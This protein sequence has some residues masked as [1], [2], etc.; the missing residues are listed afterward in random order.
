MASGPNMVERTLT[1]AGATVSE[2]SLA[3]EQ[4][5]NGGGAARLQ[6]LPLFHKLVDLREEAA[7]AAKK[8]LIVAFTSPDRFTRN[9]ALARALFEWG[10]DAAIGPPVHFLSVLPTFTG[11]AR[12]SGGGSRSRSGRVWRR[13]LLRRSRCKARTAMQWP[14][15]ST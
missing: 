8:A 7:K 6:E 11:C 9:E 12:R 14:T 3:E 10:A 5:S 2:L 13:M 4:G 1:A 15:T